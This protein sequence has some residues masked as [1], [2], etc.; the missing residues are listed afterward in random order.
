MKIAD[1][2]SV[3]VSVFKNMLVF[4]KYSICLLLTYLLNVSL[5]LK[6]F[7]VYIEF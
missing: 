2:K 3:L 1:L 5:N 4:Q 6:L 7:T